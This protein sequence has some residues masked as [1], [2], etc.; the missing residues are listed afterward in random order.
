V[1]TCLQEKRK[2]SAKRYHAKHHGEFG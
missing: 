1:N 2:W